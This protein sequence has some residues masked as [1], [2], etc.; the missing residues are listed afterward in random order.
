MVDYEFN[1]RS[2]TTEVARAALE[3]KN[4]YDEQYDK[5]YTIISIGTSPAAISEV[6]S[7]L[8][9]NV[10]FLPASGLNKI[11]SLR[12]DNPEKF[13]IQT[14]LKYMIEYVKSK[15]NNNSGTIILLDYCNTGGG[16][17]SIYEV[18]KESEICQTGRIQKHSIAEDLGLLD[19]DALGEKAKR[20]ITNVKFDLD[21]VSFEIVSNT[22][23][24]H[25]ND[26]SNNA[27]GCITSK[28]KKQQEIFDEFESY[29][30]PFAR[31]FVLCSINEAMKF[32]EKKI[33]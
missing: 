14:N 3:L 25:V 33:V 23:H 32:T 5:N 16:S 2:G 10:V 1:G 15:I 4:K 28:N 18:F 12:R 30:Q 26:N 19:F 8:G 20:K 31:A 24:F 11:P 29:S 13:I 21:H 6:M 22:P 17:N 9:C 27:I 7:A